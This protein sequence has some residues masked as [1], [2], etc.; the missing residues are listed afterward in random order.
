MRL[1]GDQFRPKLRILDYYTGGKK[2]RGIILR[3]DLHIQNHDDLLIDAMR[4]RN[5]T[6]PFEDANDALQYLKEAKYIDR[7]PRG[8][9]ERL[10]RMALE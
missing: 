9:I 8:G 3:A 1:Y 5:R 4:K 2:P 6:L 10:Y 7:E